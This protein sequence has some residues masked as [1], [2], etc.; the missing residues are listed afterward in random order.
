M[1]LFYLLV[2]ISISIA[3]YGQFDLSLSASGGLSKL[4]GQRFQNENIE[5]NFRFSTGLDLLV[6]LNKSK[7]IQPFAGCSFYV[8]QSNLVY[9]LDWNLLEHDNQ[10]R[11]NY[12][13]I[14]IGVEVPVFKTLGIRLALVN[15]FLVGETETSPEATKYEFGLQPGLSYSLDKWKIG[16]NYYHGFTNVF[17]QAELSQN[18]DYW[19]T[20]NSAF[21]I[22]VGYKILT[23]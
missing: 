10:F 6:Q 22:T 2:L 21:Y 5:S 12:L 17:D 3:S 15:G 14:P 20:K 23:F 13:R 9:P 19:E 7:H 18:T 11:F 1:K 16:L 8:L 4:N